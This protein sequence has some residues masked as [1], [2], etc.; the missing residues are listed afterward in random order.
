MYICDNRAPAGAAADTASLASA[1]VD[2]RSAL[3]VLLAVQEQSRQHSLSEQRSVRRTNRRTPNTQ[4]M[5]GRV[6]S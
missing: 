4:P 5:A 2:P 3:L 1:A 6:H